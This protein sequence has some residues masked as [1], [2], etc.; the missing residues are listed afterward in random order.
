MSRS[1]NLFNRN[2]PTCFVLRRE[3]QHMPI[4]EQS[5]YETDK[6][7]HLRCSTKKAVHKNFAKHLFW[8]LFWDK[9]KI[10]LQAVRPAILPKREFYQK[11][12]PTQIFSCEYCNI[13]NTCFE[14]HLQTKMLLKIIKKDF[15]EKPP[16]PMII[17][18]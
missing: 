17:T 12:N 11:E 7:S 3:D 5:L 16:V 15:L 14:E 9:I 18:W 8:N 4:I 10:K 1:T 2:H 13:S 6:S